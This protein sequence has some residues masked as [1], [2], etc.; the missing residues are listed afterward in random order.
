MIRK[1]KWFWMWQDDREAAWLGEM[2]GQGLHLKSLGLFGWYTFERGA[3]RRYAYYVDFI[4]QSYKENEAVRGLQQI[5]WKH[6]DQLGSWHYWRKELQEGEY[7]DIYMSPQARLEK[8]QRLLGMLIIFL[9]IFLL[10]IT[11]ADELLHRYETWII[12]ALMGIFY[13]LVPVYLF[14]LVSTL[15]RVLLLRRSTK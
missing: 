1:F 10:P 15:R 7:P 2:S 6:V 8:Y 3:P 11:R 5:G 12:R 14:A 13:T 4:T 9:P